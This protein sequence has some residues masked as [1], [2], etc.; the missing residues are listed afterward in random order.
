MLSYV[1]FMLFRSDTNTLTHAAHLRCADARP[2][3]DVSRPRSPSEH[4]HS[5]R[6]AVSNSRMLSTPSSRHNH[7]SA[8]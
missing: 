1:L 8:I 4:V 7:S 3:G 2:L 6:A 5:A